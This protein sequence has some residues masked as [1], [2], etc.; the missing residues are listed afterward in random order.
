MSGFCK[1]SSLLQKQAKLPC[2]PSLL[3]LG[4]VNDYRI[5]E[6]LSSDLLDKW[7]LDRFDA[8]T[9]HVAQLFSALGKILLNEDF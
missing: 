2:S 9:E 8:V 1:H 3:A 7:R 5:E 6:T 4:L